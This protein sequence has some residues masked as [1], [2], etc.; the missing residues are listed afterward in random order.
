[1]LD[2]VVFFDTKFVTWTMQ[3]AAKGGPLTV[4]QLAANGIRLAA[5]AALEDGEAPLPGTHANGSERSQGRNVHTVW[6]WFVL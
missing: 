6:F 1:L 4:R 2:D 3:D 5:A